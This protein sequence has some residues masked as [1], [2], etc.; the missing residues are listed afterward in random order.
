MKCCIC[1]KEIENYG[2]NPEGAYDETG[3]EIRWKS[4]DRC[5]D[6]CNAKYV[7]AGRIAKLYQTTPKNVKAI[8][9]DRLVKKK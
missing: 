8:M 4:D 2:N 5:C 9:P 1:G 3:H 6:A 7:V